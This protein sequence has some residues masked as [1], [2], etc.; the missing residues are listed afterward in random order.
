ME[1][2]YS[3]IDECYPRP[4]SELPVTGSHLL[5][6]LEDNRRPPGDDQLR[7]GPFGKHGLMTFELYNFPAAPA[8]LRHVIIPIH[9]GGVTPGRVTFRGQ[10]DKRHC[11]LVVEGAIGD[12]RADCSAVWAA[13][14]EGTNI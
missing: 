7:V 14:G 9:H 12:E 3:W 2:V 4:L 11:P 5:T 10:G 6:P 8:L 13:A 1:P